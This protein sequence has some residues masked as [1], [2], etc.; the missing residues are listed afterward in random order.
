M[1]QGVVH[2]IFTYPPSIQ[3]LAFLFLVSNRNTRIRRGC[4]ISCQKNYW[5]GLWSDEQGPGE[6]FFP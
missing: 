1:E 4:N 5:E 2:V 3:I 6:L